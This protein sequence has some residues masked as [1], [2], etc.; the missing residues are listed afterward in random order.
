MAIIS[1]HFVTPLFS[2]AIESYMYETDFK[3]GLSQ[4]YH[5]VLSPLIIGSKLTVISSSGRLV[6]PYVEVTS[7]MEFWKGAKK[8][9][10]G[11]F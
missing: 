1:I 3:L 5:L 4:K 2:F 7:K 6:A 11:Y 9:T 10:F 8:E